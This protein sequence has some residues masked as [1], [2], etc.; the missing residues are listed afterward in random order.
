M[1]STIQNTNIKAKYVLE[2]LINGKIVHSKT[3]HELLESFGKIQTEY[4]REICCVN[5]PKVY[6]FLDKNEP[7][8]HNSVKPIKENPLSNRQSI[9]AFAAI[10]QMNEGN[11]S[12]AISEYIDCL[13]NYNQT[14]NTDRRLSKSEIVFF[15]TLTFALMKN[16]KK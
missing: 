7:I 9:T 13:L 3:E 12:N 5:L 15:K 11:F 1:F 14:G 16:F 8:D 6:R 10:A 2:I 4:I